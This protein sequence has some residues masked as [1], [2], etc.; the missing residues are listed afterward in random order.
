LKGFR[1]VVR[2]AYDLEFRE[3]RMK[4]LTA[5]ATQLATDLPVWSEDFGE[6][7]R[8]EQGWR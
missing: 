5:L 7:V 8:A 1:H 3:E 4:E 6:R 2:H